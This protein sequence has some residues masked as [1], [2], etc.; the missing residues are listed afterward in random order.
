MNFPGTRGVLKGNKPP[1][2]CSTVSESV[3]A[4]SLKTSGFRGRLQTKLPPTSYPS[5]FSIEWIMAF[6]RIRLKQISKYLKWAM[7]EWCVS[8][9]ATAPSW[10]WLKNQS[11]YNTFSHF[12]KDNKT[13]TDIRLKV[14]ADF[15]SDIMFSN[16]HFYCG[17]KPPRTF[18]STWTT[19]YRV[20]PWAWGQQK[21]SAQK[22][23]TTTTTPLNKMQGSVL[24]T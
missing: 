8:C 4:G 19:F 18:Y 9:F 13:E 11:S 14:W 6:I 15:L 22:T 23:T 20:S 3:L 1:G 24:Q 12:K 2:V 16:Q 21:T 7:L 10:L 5:P 17:T